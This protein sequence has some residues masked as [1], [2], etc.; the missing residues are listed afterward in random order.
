MHQA[1]LFHSSGSSSQ[2]TNQIAQEAQRI[3]NSIINPLMQMNAK[4]VMAALMALA[5]FLYN[6]A[7]A[8]VGLSVFGLAYLLL[9]RTVRRRLT[10]NGSGDHRGPAPA[11]QADGGGLRRHQGRAAARSPAGHDHPALRTAPAHASP[12]PRAPRHG[13]GAGP[14][15][16]ME[17]IAFGS[18]I[19]L[20]LYLLASPPGQSGQPSCRVLSRLTPWPA[21]SCCRPSSRSTRA[22]RSIRGNLAAFEA[23]RDDLRAS[24]PWQAATGRGQRRKTSDA[25]LAP[26][27]QSIELKTSPSRYPGKQEPALNGREH[28]DPRQPA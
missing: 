1:W 16:A 8:L 15:Y 17:L 7:V 19:F 14:R 9:Y 24:Q 25:H 20:I 18:V 23:L 2:L 27:I 5:I 28:G 11:L 4:L 10:A 6:P 22:S 12:E 21:S 13:D 26:E 3:T